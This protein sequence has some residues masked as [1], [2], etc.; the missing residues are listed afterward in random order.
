[1]LWAA[2]LG[3]KKGPIWIELSTNL[4]ASTLTW[5]PMRVSA[6]VKRPVPLPRF[7]LLVL[8]GL[9]SSAHSYAQPIPS[10]DLRG[11]RPPTAPDSALYLEPTRTPGGSEWN[12]G[13][14]LSYAHRPVTLRDADGEHRASVIAHQFSVDY[15]ASFGIGERLAIGLSLPSVVYQDGDDVSGVIGSEELP[16][17]AM[18]DIGFD[19]KATLLPPGELGG[20]GLAALGRVTAPTGDERSY[21]GEGSVTGEM[22]LLG[23]IKLI[24]LDLRASAGAKIRA[25]EDEYVGENFSHQLPWGVGVAVRPQA[26]GLDERGRWMWNLEVRGALALV[27]EFGSGPQSPAAVGV[28]ARYSVGDLSALGG[29]EL[30]LNGAVGVP[31]VRPVLALGWAPRFHD[32]DSDGIEDERDQCAD[33]AEDKDGF[34]DQDGCPDFDDDSDGVPDDE[35]RCADHLEDLDEHADEDGCPD[36]DNDG[37]R[38][39]DTQDACPNQAGIA[40]KHP[41]QNGCPAVDTD[42]DGSLDAEDRCPRAAEDKDG[43]Q[44]DDGCPDHDNDRDRV[45]DVDDA[46]PNERGPERSDPDLNGCPSPDRD[47]DTY[48]DKED[49]CPDVPEDFDGVD[50][51]DG[52]V[53][54]EAAKPPAQRGKPLVTLD[55]VQ[56]RWVLSVK[57]PIVF[58]KDGLTLAPE[59]ALSLRAIAQKLNER[60]DFVLIAGVRPTGKTPA[61]EQL[62]LTKS[63][64]LVNEIRALTHRDEAAETIGWAAVQAQPGAGASGIGFM[65]LASR[66]PDPKVPASPQSAPA[67]P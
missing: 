32:S 2:L 59:T 25:E 21:L 42:Q 9:L 39:L 61:A 62:A 26:L 49:R 1:L 37:D 38:I 47:G 55:Q 64:V 52:C 65:I 6:P 16:T 29:V 50:D 56:G 40:S 58:Q 31:N 60:P 67:K 18:G 53:D 43:F 24:A 41:K 15:L 57:K 36:P 33:L 34:E 44:D 48:D 27:P 12:V 5:R 28:S 3:K 7:P 19:A 13:A 17:T 10:L 11:F 23:E 51:T 35:D 45:Q 20:L 63:F 22:R 4:R 46:C 66:P 54:D 30:P 14:W 8:A